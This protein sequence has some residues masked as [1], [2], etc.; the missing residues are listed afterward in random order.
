MD[1]KKGTIYKTLDWQ[2]NSGTVKFCHSL[3]EDSLVSQ[4]IA[5]KKA[6]F[7]CAVVMKATMYR[8]TFIV[9]SN[10]KIVDS[11][12]KMLVEQSIEIEKTNRSI[13]SPKFLPMVIYQGEKAD[14]VPDDTMGL[15]H[16]WVENKFTLRKGSILAIDTGREYLLGIGH[17]LKV[18]PNEHMQGQMQVDVAESDGGYFIVEVAPDLHES[19]RRAQTE[20]EAKC[21]HRDS[22]LTH[23]L[24]VGFAKFA[25]AYADNSSGYKTLENFQTVKR[26][27]EAK[28]I[29]TWGNG[30]EFDP[31]KAACAFKPHN[32][33]SPTATGEEE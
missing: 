9:D 18:R 27:L 10:G 3:S 5:E 17:L 28:N 29:P 6:C 13:E 16:L 23:A 32:L 21:R 31:C 20:G 2:V 8:K 7:G 19:L 33:G 30:D 11:N 4:L 26:Q 1:Y 25:K 24:S 15:D 12:G 22:V 14:I